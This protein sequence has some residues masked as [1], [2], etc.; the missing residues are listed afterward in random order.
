MLKKLLLSSL[1]IVLASQVQ[2]KT[3]TVKVFST[4]SNTPI[5][6]VIFKETQYGLLITPSL[7]ALTPGLHGFHIHEHSSCKQE[8]MSAGGHFDPDKSNKHLGPYG[9]GHLG[10][11]PAL[12]VD[13]AGEAHQPLLA[14][15]IKL[16]NLTALSLMIHSGG[17]NYSDIPKALG[18]GGGRVACGVITRTT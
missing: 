14:P 12:F 8:G 6:L 2:A 10:D 1:I 17:D 16:S 15:R 4:T 9:Q 13:K 5:G 3:L 18:G 7:S 11:L